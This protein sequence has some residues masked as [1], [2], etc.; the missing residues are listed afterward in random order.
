MLQCAAEL[1]FICLVGLEDIDTTLKINRWSTVENN[2]A[3]LELTNLRATEKL[4]GELVNSK[5]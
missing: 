3:M 5:S 4:N 2:G 1:A